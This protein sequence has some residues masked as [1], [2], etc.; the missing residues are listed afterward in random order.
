MDSICKTGNSE[1]RAIVDQALKAE[2]AG[3]DYIGVGSIFPTNTKDDAELVGLETLSKVRR[4]VKIP[5]VAI[6]GVGRLR[7]EVF[8]G[9]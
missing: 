3:A 5:L 1:L 7:N 4:A 8:P 6:G 2:M 9:G